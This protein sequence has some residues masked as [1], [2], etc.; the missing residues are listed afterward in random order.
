M[1]EYLCV[2]AIKYLQYIFLKHVYYMKVNRWYNNFSGTSIK[3]WTNRTIHY[4]Q[5]INV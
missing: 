2:K 1:V 4:K 5:T 3:S